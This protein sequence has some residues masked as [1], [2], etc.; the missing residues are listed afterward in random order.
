VNSGDERVRP[1]SAAALRRPYR[2]GRWRSPA[3]R[4][5]GIDWSLDRAPA[6]SIAR[7]SRRGGRIAIEW[8]LD[9]AMAG[10]NDQS[11]AAAA[12]AL[13]SGQH[14]VVSGRQLRE[15]GFG[16]EAIQHR[17]ERG[18]L[19]PLWR[20]VFAV[21]RPEVS[22]RGLWKAA[23]L[24]CGA[25]AA[26]SHDSAA[27]LWG[28]RSARTSAVDVSVPGE[29]ARHHRIRCHRRAA[30]PLTTTVDSIPVTRPLFT[31][32][33]LAAQLELEDL[34]RALNDGDR[35]KLID[36]DELVALVE[37]LPGRRG[38]RKLRRLLGAYTRTD[39]E[40]ERRFLTLAE[41]AGLRRPQTQAWVAGLRVDFLWPEL[42][43]VVE[44][45]GLV[46]HRTPAQ[47]ALD[48]KRD[49]ALTAAGFIA[50][51]FTNAQVRL[52]PELV[53]A[54]LRATTARLETIARR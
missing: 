9:R 47:Q 37:S 12:W 3:G 50:L 19:H 6:P 2:R 5:I 33:D 27:A 49:Q 38:I 18:R 16:P 41:R 21:G 42:R 4:T 29:R 28:I 54:T 14:W 34:T 24:V 20:G 11:M 44:T 46:Y 15:L 1:E 53:I 22:D 51:R 30:M 32:V 35:L 26:L 48:R 40:L 23:T 43:L 45:D 52:E 7:S 8:S 13:A 39:S 25:G 31:L 10:S 17:I 36:H